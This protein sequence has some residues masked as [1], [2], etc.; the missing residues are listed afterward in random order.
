M[1]RTLFFRKFANQ[2]MQ[3]YYKFLKFLAPKMINTIKFGM[4]GF[5]NKLNIIYKTVYI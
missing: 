3:T 2:K 1:R 5:L 4:S